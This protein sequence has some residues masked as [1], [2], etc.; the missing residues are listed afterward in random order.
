M[1][2]NGGLLLLALG[3]ALLTARLGWW[4]LDRAAQKVAMQ[5][6]L[7][8]RAAMPALA[9]ADWPRDAAAASRVEYRHTQATGVWLNELSIYLDNRPQAGRTGFLLVTPLRLDDGTAILVQRGWQPRDQMDRTRVAPPPVAPGAVTVSGRIAPALPRVFEF[10]SAASGTIRQNLGIDSYAIEARLRL[11][12][13]VL[14]QEEGPATP[15]DGL[16]RQ[17][18]APNTGVQTHYGYAFQWFSLS[19]LTVVLYVW[20]QLIRPRRRAGA[21]REA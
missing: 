16:L 10:D 14:I 11:R 1:R 18:P 6:S 13:W 7:D 5:Q 3:V 15:A 12:P 17:A 19:A 8:S 9:A 21:E 2:V 20:F 4:Q